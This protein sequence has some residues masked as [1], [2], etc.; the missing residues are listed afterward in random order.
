MSVNETI[1]V[2]NYAKDLDINYNVKLIILC[3]VVVYSVALIWLSFKWE[4]E[5]LWVQVV[6]W[7]IMRLPSFIFLFFSPLYVIYL[8]RTASYNML[9]ALMGTY[10]SYVFVVLLVAGNLGMFSFMLKMFGFK[11]IQKVRLK[12]KR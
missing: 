7:A 6:Q 5:D 8:W 2:L 3:F 9:Y 11:G 12:R 1:Q 10:Y 4:S